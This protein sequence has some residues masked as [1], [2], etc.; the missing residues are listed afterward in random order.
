MVSETWVNIGS[1]DD[2]LADGTKP[3]PQ[4]VLFDHQ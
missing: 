1:G 3:L 2:L 4:P